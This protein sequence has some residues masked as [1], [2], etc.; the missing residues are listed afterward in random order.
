VPNPKTITV[1]GIWPRTAK[2]PE[3][4]HHTI[5]RYFEFNDQPCIGV[6]ACVPVNEILRVLDL[7]RAS[8]ASHVW[9]HMPGKTEKAASTA[10]VGQGGHDHAELYTRFESGEK[11]YNIAAAMNVHVRSIEYVYNKWKA[12][13]PAIILKGR[14]RTGPL[15]HEAIMEDIRLGIPPTEVA[16][17][18]DCTRM[19]IYNI[20][21]RYKTA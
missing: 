15:D 2:I 13:K 3:I 4:K 18:Y 6:A 8:G 21:K 14:K 5:F 9:Y 16:K 17:K 10:T 20:T 11:P 12:G 7:Y 1:A 19:M